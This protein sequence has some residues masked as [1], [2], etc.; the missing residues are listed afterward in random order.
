M[1]NVMNLSLKQRDGAMA[2]VVGM[3]FLAARSAQGA[4]KDQGGRPDVGEWHQYS[5]DL[6]GTK[7]SPLDHI[8][9]S[10]VQNLAVAWRWPAADRAIQVSNPL[11]RAGRNEDTPLMINGMLY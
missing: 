8:D 7:Y 1:R 9:R 5:N 10:N 11:W 3:I 6:Q 2:V 4:V